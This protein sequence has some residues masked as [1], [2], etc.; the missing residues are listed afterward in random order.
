VK[1]IAKK[2]GPILDLLLEMFES[3]S[4]TRIR[5]MLKYQM[6]QVGG[7][8]V[9]RV[10]FEVKAGEVVEYLKKT[11]SGKEIKAPVPIVFEDDYVLVAEKPA[12]LLTYGE[13][14]TGGTSLYRVLRDFIQER[15]NSSRQLYV[16]HRLDREVSGIVVFAK[17]ERIQQ[18]IKTNWKETKKLYYALV[19]G[20]PQKKQGTLRSWLK[21]GA[22]RKMYSA[23]KPQAAKRAVTH[24]RVLKVLPGHTLLEIEPETG[25]K[26][27]I[28][29]HLS[30]MGCPVVG[31]RRYGA[32]DKILRRIRLHGFY[33]GFTHP[34]TGRFVEFRS[35]MPKGFLIL[36]A[37]PEK[38]K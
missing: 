10:D 25:R 24:Y 35:P 23:A 12:G 27:Q 7:R 20:R 18:Q 8:P 5:K 14:G 22:D 4:K 16:V 34:V 29:V 9:T 28:R 32:N 31:D 6:V 1:T 30:E 15:T 37:K 19:E 17:H 33:L 26:N 11:G 13:K 21:E 36:G 2:D 3:A 38:Y